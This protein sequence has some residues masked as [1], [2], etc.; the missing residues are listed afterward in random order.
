MMDK[1]KYSE[2]PTEVYV[3]VL[4][5][6]EASETSLRRNSSAKLVNVDLKDLSQRITRIINRKFL[7]IIHILV[8][9]N[10]KTINVHDYVVFI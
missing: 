5:K 1:A 4:R 8:H 9:T 6:D 3:Q 2:R 10:F 7:N